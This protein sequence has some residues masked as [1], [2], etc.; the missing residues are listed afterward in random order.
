MNKIKY[1]PGLIIFSLIFSS[2]PV[3]SV[4][5]SEAQTP[6]EAVETIIEH[7]ISDGTLNSF[8]LELDYTET[9]TRQYIESTSPLFLEPIDSPDEPPFNGIGYLYIEHDSGITTHGTAFLVGKNLALTA[10]HCVDD[11]SYGNVTHMYLYVGLNGEGNRLA[12][13]AASSFY[14]SSFWDDSSSGVS[15][16]DWA[17]I[18]LR[19]SMDS[20]R[21]SILPCAVRPMKGK[22]V[23]VSGYGSENG[24]LD[25]YQNISEGTVTSDNDWLLNT[26]AEGR[27]G[28]S[29]SPMFDMENFDNT[30]VGIA[31]GT[32]RINNW[33]SGPKINTTIVNLVNDFNSKN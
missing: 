9:D 14:V 21:T 25:D 4:E 28:M 2:S 32:R 23:M 30:V 7:N 24:G 29:G 6:N 33:L 22:T 26:T 18:K 13:S 8:D 27:G 16:Y 15:E 10:A 17:L 12:A 19:T 5:A 11:A 1:F 31:A 3:L 20:T